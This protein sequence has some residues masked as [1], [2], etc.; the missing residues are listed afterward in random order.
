MKKEEGVRREDSVRLNSAVRLTVVL[1]GLACAGRPGP[2]TAVLPQTTVGSPDAFGTGFVLARPYQV[3]VVLTAPAYLTLVRV[4]SGTEAEVVFPTAGARGP[5][6]L[7]PGSWSLP[8]PAARSTQVRATPSRDAGPVVGYRWGYALNGFRL[9]CV[10]TAQRPC[11]VAVRAGEVRLPPAPFLPPR[12][13][14][15]VFVL[16]ASEQPIDPREA[17]ARLGVH[18]DVGSATAIEVAQAIPGMLAA[19]QHAG[20]GAWIVQVL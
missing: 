12:V 16:I 19:D 13:G 17:T 1:V 20:W 7:G 15:H 10:G 8:V 18:P 5:A 14:P 2:T 4:W 9:G 6:H 3:R 11:L